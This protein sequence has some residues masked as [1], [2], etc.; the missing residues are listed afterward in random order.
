MP[1]VLTLLGRPDPTWISSFLPDCRPETAAASRPCGCWTCR[2]TNRLRPAWA[3]CGS[4]ARVHWTCGCPC[5]ALARLEHSQDTRGSQGERVAGDWC[6]GRGCQARPDRVSAFALVSLYAAFSGGSQVYSAGRKPTFAGRGVRRA[7]VAR[8]TDPS[9]VPQSAAARLRRD[10]DGPA[11]RAGQPRPCA[12]PDSGLGLRPDPRAPRAPRTQIEPGATADREVAIK[13]PL[14]AI[15]ERNSYANIARDR[16]SRFEVRVPG[17]QSSLGKCQ[18]CSARC[19]NSAALPEGANR[20]LR[21][22]RLDDSTWTH[23]GR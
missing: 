5:P 6:G 20:S 8:R 1:P 2:W 10:H 19:V 7:R 21:G 17:G 3:R 18:L 14:V 16:S 23:S 4:G 12:Q 15:N 22:R 13:V 11:T 9:V